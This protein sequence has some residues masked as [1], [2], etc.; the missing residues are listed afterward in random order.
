L[1]SSGSDF[2]KILQKKAIKQEDKKDIPG[3]NIARQFS[4][5]NNVVV[6]VQR[7]NLAT[8]VGDLELVVRVF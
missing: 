8:R 2:E 1:K 7:P 5:Q 3:S 6:M 4:V